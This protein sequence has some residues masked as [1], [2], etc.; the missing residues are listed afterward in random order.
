MQ[1]VLIRHG[2]TAGNAERRYIGRTDDPLSAKGI[3]AAQASGSAPGVAQVFVTP[4]RRTQQT[5]QILLPNA[6]QTVIPALRE[7][8]FGDFEGRN[9]DEM[10]HDTAYRAW[11]D[12]GGLGV[13]PNGESAEGFSERVCAGFIETLKPLPEGTKR[14]VFVVHGGTIMALM[15]RFARPEIAYFDAYV[16]NCCGYTAELLWEDEMPVLTQARR[17]DRAAEVLG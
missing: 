10:E 5:A 9:A 1:I 15:A 13:C 11:V 3:A 8:D 17:F 2:E 14:A 16:K 12:G 7:M 4:L 6:V